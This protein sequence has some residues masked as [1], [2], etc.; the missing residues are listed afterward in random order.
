VR[1]PEGYSDALTVRTGQDRRVHADEIP[2][3]DALVRA[4]VASQFPSLAGLAV[5]RVASTGTVNAIFR[6]GAELSVRLPLKERWAQDLRHEAGVTETVAPRVSPQVPSLAGLGAPGEGYPCE[7][8][9][10]RWIPG[11]PY[12]DEHIA[13]ERQA[14][15]DLAGFVAELREIPLDGAPPA[16]RRPLKEL[17]A[18]TRQ[19]IEASVPEIDAPAAL[20]V[21]ERALAAPAWDGRRTWMH[22][23]LLRPNL[24]ASGGRL[25][26]VIDF[27]LAGAGDGAQDVIAA[28]TVFGPAGRAAY[29]AA[30]DVDD[31][32]WNRARGIALHQAAMII[33]Y[34]RHTNPEFAALARR[35]ITQILADG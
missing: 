13:D 1:T 6:L 14:A 29:R 7:W 2:V 23:D 10:Y 26:A 32:T 8:A 31:A 18:A 22:G 35:T 11:H 25:T 16:G 17:D 19:A 5:L 15:S 27:G 24:L 4:L 21:W 33:P 12:D 34:Y 30:L 20:E 28:W 9:I 3:D